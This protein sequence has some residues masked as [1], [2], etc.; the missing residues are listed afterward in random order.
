[1]KGYRVSA[2]SRDTPS[3]AYLSETSGPASPVT[4]PVLEYSFAGM[5]SRCLAVRALPVPTSSLQS[6]KPTRGF[7]P[8]TPSLRVKARLVDGFPVLRANAADAAGRLLVRRS[9]Q[10]PRALQ[11]CV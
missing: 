2:R 5:C 1:M 8:R 4:S 11:R 3:R 7:E 9:P 6:A 10:K